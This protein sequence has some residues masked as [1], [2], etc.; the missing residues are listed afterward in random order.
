MGNKV[1]LSD[2]AAKGVRR[3]MKAKKIEGSLADGLEVMI[4]RAVGRQAA[5]DRYAERKAAGEVG[6]EPK[7]KKAKKDKSAKKAK[8][9]KAAAKP[10]K[11]KSAK[12]AKKDKATKPKKPKKV[13]EAEE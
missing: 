11:D 10:K 3:F 5:L 7:A 6:A 4:T 12:K 8:K 1:T 2:D 13:K 9:D